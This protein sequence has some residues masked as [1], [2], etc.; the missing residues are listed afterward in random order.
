MPVRLGK[1]CNLEKTNVTFYFQTHQNVSNMKLW[2]V[3]EIVLIGELVTV[4]GK[5]K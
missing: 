2:F 4:S 3:N 5:L 1:S